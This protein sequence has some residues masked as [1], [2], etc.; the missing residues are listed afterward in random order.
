M[1]P[2]WPILHIALRGASGL[3]IFGK[4]NRSVT[5]DCGQPAQRTHVAHFDDSL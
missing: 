2:F 1:T 4:S 3:M 5:H